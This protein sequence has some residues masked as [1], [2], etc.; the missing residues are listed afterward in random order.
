MRIECFTGGL[1]ATNGYLVECADGW[2]AV[3]APEGFAAH[4]RGRKLL[5]LV[6]T[7]G[8]WDHIWDAA[9]LAAEHGCPVHYH[10][11]D[12]PL[13]TNPDL[14]AGFGLPVR[15]KPLAATTHPR[16][17]DVLRFAPWNFDILH[18]PGHCPGSICLLEKEAGVLFGGDVLFAGAVGRWDLPHGDQGLL[19]RGI[20]D[21]LMPLPDTT[22]VYP[23]HGEATTIGRERD[24]NPFCR[25][26]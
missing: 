22:V 9:D 6:L 24:T 25:V 11:D 8:H 23:G 20:R 18:V 12:A 2:L 1:A 16:E 4:C 15:L 13:I 21:K 3:D 19:L 10:A 14:M 7:H 26:R 5:A 17:G